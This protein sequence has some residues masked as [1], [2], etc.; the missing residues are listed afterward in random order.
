MWLLLLLVRINHFP[1]EVTSSHNIQADFVRSGTAS[2]DQIR[3]AFCLLLIPKLTQ[4]LHG[5]PCH[6]ATACMRAERQKCHQQEE[7]TI[8]CN[9]ESVRSLLSDIKRNY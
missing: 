6:L 9:E 8:G 5:L 1:Q 4:N 2:A 3:Y 7:Y